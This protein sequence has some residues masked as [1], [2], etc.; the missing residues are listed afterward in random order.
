M[1]TLGVSYKATEW[2]QRRHLSTGEAVAMSLVITTMAGAMAVAFL[3][4]MGNLIF[5][6]LS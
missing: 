3:A 4:L 5:W 1:R 6:L 2:D